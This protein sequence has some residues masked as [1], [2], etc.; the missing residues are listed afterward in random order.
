MLAA[1]L[2]ATNPNV[3]YLQ[4]TP[5]TEPLFFG[6][7]SLQVWLFTRWV[8]DGAIER[9]PPRGRMGNGSCLSHAL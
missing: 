1:T 2:F 9:P 5:M 3:L 4:A 7:T 8:M 6:L